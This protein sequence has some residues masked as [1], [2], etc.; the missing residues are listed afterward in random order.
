MDDVSGSTANFTDKGATNTQS[1]MMLDNEEIPL[2]TDE[3][4]PDDN[5]IAVEAQH[6]KIH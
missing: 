3:D 6:N 2:V 5:F 1:R 4:D